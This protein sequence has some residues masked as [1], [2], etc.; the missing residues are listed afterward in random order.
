MKLL[1]T[2]PSSY[3]LLYIII[4]LFLSHSIFYL[5]YLNLFSIFFLILLFTTTL[6]QKNV[7]FPQF[8]F[9]PKYKDLKI[10]HVLILLIIIFP[11]IFF[12]NN[13]SFGD[14][15]WGGDHRDFVLASLVNNEFWISSIMSPKDKIQNLNIENI[16]F[17]FLKSRIFLLLIIIS[18]TVFLYKK[19]YGNLANILLL[20]IFFNF[21]ING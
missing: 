11:S 4:C 6:F 12:L 3:Y 13:I 16:F 20:I 14:F 15:N 1:K 8:D 5:K 17:F 21:K 9:K 19:K 7:I 10:I 2:H 18:L